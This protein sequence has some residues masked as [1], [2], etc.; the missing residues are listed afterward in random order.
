MLN[1]LHFCN[2]FCS[3]INCGSG[4]GR[5]EVLPLAQLSSGFVWARRVS[6][7]VLLVTNITNCNTTNNIFGIFIIE[8]KGFYLFAL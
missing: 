1:K 8:Q 7:P 6:A 5:V 3:W 4:A 2:C